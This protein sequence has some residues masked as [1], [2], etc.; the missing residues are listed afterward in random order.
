MGVSIG[1]DSIPTTIQTGKKRFRSSVGIG[2]VAK[3][4]LSFIDAY[5]NVMQDVLGNGSDHSICNRRV[6][7]SCEILA[8]TQGN[9]KIHK[10]FY[11][12]WIDHVD[13][14]NVVY[15]SFNTQKI[16]FVKNVGR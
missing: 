9:P 8:Y 13:K 12:E 10:R 15:T 5:E 14:V 16:S 4:P 1:I 7:S 6:L 2:I 11:A 3:D